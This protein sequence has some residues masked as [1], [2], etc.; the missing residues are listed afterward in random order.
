MRL[1]SKRRFVVLGSVAFVLTIG[2]VATAYAKVRPGTPI[3]VSNL[4]HM[5]GIIA[6]LALTDLSKVEEHAKGIKANAAILKT[7]KVTDLGMNIPASKQADF[8]KYATALETEAG[9]V[10]EACQKAQPVKVV[11]GFRNMIAN[12][13]FACHANVRDP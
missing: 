11:D 3:M 5:D 13:C 12:G 10:V 4:R 9:N 1:A 6:G 7:V 8:V 2:I